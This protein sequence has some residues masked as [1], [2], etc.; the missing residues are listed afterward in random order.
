M[1]PESSLPHSQVPSTCL[2]PEPTQSS[3]HPTSYF[4]KIHLN[5]IPHLNLGL[6]SRL[7][8][9]GF[10]TKTLSYASPLSIRAKCTAHR[11]LLD[12]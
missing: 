4:L 5:I 7:F 8:P 11:I 6:P 2:Y 9:S 10:R 3:P 1:E 12:L